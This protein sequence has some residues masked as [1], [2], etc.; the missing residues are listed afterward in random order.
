MYLC[1]VYLVISVTTVKK[2]Q[3][4][5]HRIAEFCF[6]NREIK[7]LCS[8]P[9]SPSF[10]KKRHF[11]TKNEG[12]ST[13]QNKEQPSKQ[14]VFRLIKKVEGF[15]GGLLDKNLPA[16]AGVCASRSVMSDSLRPH[17]L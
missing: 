4:V 13:S 9:S 7:K 11:N 17:G 3:E 16:S 6:S 14:N 2:N 10:L 12:G 15:P 1:T 8:L 5:Q